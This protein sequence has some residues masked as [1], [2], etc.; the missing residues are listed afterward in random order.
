VET[1]IHN[2]G[3]V[4]VEQ[5][6]CPN[7]SSADAA[8]TMSWGFFGSAIDRSDVWGDDKV[9][10]RLE[11]SFELCNFANGR[12]DEKHWSKQTCGLSTHKQ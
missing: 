9:P 2:L 8:A 4:E 5:Y 3:G 7:Q 12:F 11:F 10:T 6:M 1:S